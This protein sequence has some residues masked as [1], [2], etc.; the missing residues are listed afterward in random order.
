MT[1]PTATPGTASLSQATTTAQHGGFVWHDMM[2]PDPEASQ[3]FYS[4]VLGWELQPWNGPLPYSM[5][6]ASGAPRGGFMQLPQDVQQQGVPAH[7]LSY[8][9]TAD[10]DHSASKA[11]SLGAKVL[12][13]PQDIPGVGR[14]AVIQD[15]Q[16]ATLA[17][18]ASATHVPDANEVA[19]LGDAS[20]HELWTTDAA[21]AYDFY[22]SLFG[23]EGAGEFDMGP[24]LGP[25]RMFGR[26]G[27]GLG[28]MARLLPEMQG[29]PPHWLPYFHVA[30]VADTVAKVKANGGT[31]QSGPMQVPGG[32]TVAT[33][34]DPQGGAFAVHEVKK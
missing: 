16:G 1:T 31:V 2:T 26:R 23:W 19:P 32:D 14:F 33:C 21:N 29:V 27:V 34:V 11:E 7:W 13:K 25:Y 20:W 3:R 4:A 8:V 24:V 30:S 5:F 22:T 12:V 6:V 15:P 18:Y 10:V 9:G 17:L 28:G